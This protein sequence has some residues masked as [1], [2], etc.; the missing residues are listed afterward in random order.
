MT[1]S[2]RPEPIDPADDSWP[3][4]DPDLTR[5]VPM[6]TPTGSRTPDAG[7][8]G[9]SGPAGSTTPGESGDAGPSGAPDPGAA[10]TAAGDAP[11]GWSSSGTVASSWNTPEPAAQPAG[12]ATTPPAAS[13]S[14][15]S[16]PATTV[17]GPPSG[18]TPAGPTPVPYPAPPAPS[19]GYGYASPTTVGTAAGAQDY[20]G[21]F[22]GGPSYQQPFGPGTGATGTGSG[23]Q[24]ILPPATNVI[25]P[26]TK[27]PQAE[28]R[29]G[30]NAIGTILGILLVFGGLILV[31]R[32]GGFRSPDSAGQ[33]T[34]DYLKFTWF[35]LGALLV[36][37]PTFLVT[38]AS[39]TALVPGLIV[40]GASVW[41]MV[42]TMSTGGG[43]Y[44]IDKA[45]GW[46]FGGLTLGQFAAAG[47]GLLVGLPLL[48]TGLAAV[49]LRAGVRRTI[50]KQVQSL[51][52]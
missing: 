39:W 12:P 30:I 32:F 52:Q 34:T 22:G 5:V 50:V 3:Q 16:E 17:V 15:S 40:T 23:P 48:L 38:W 25:L 36:A 47:Y 10:P 31:L 44:Y 19:G 11:S 24:V 51:Q 41:A 4:E 26:P 45:T 7:A 37:L 42:T 13:P 27:I 20:A 46:A 28:S 35:V 8:G 49:F 14:Y 33:S 6:G 9:S 21:G 1:G 43:A 18:P 2:D 29:V